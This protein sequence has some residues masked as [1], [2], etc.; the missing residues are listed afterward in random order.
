MEMGPKFFIS[1]PLM[2]PQTYCN[3]IPMPLCSCLPCGISV[4]GKFPISGCDCGL[5]C[6]D[7]KNCL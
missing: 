3:F 7:V 5:P 4:G 1:F 6:V 2:A